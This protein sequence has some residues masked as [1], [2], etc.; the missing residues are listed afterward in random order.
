[1]KFCGSK[2]FR[3]TKK[4]IF[5]FSA[6]LIS[7]VLLFLN[8]IW[9][10]FAFM[11]VLLLT[12]LEGKKLLLFIVIVS[13][14]TLTST[15]SVALRTAVQYL[16][17]I[18]LFYLFIKKFGLN[19]SKYPI[20]PKEIKLLI[21]LV[22]LAMSFA[23]VF[24]SHIILGI[25]QIVRTIIFFVIVYFIYSLVENISDI[26]LLLFA[27]FT[28][29]IIYVLTLFIGFAKNNF[30]LVQMNINRVDKVSNDYINVNAIASFF[31]IVIPIALSFFL[32]LK[33][34][35]I[36]L[37]LGVFLFITLFGLLISNSRAAI[38]ALALE[39]I[40]IFYNLNRK[41]LKI[42]LIFAIL[43]TPLFFINS[44]SE[45]IDLYFRLK[46]LSTG[47]DVIW[48]VIFKIIKD[49]YIL[50]VGPA[51]TKY[52]LFPHSDYLISSHQARFLAFHYNEIEFGHAHN[53]YLFF[54]SD[55]GLLGLFTSLLLPFTYFKLGYITSKRFNILNRNYYLL[56]LGLIA[57]GIGLF[58][59]AIFE[60]G[61]LISYGTIGTDLPFWLAFIMLAYF[62][63]KTSNK[64]AEVL[65]EK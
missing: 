32:D 34:N 16:N 22:F 35:R 33:K 63:K 57:A 23:T 49:N 41:I 14:L 12:I 9:V 48:D 6:L 26:R 20:I 37:F 17:I 38:L 50:G 53:F 15:I 2:L 64:K 62:Y 61:N 1:M 13:F 44:I 60:W 51:A 5:L 40:F 56:T 19:F 59:R 55:L 36:K 47:R 54:W 46:H 24:S 21:V 43:I 25:E 29:A 65:T 58:I 39:F 18:I 10:A 52:F 11:L 7:I 30:D 27:L 45:Y 4:E 31:I 8:Y 42:T 3:N 28:V